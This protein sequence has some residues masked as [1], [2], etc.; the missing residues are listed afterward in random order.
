[1]RRKLIVL[2]ALAVLMA[3]GAGCSV[4]KGMV[5]GEPVAEPTEE[6]AT[7]PGRPDAPASPDSD[8]RADPASVVAA[9]GRP[10]LIEFFAFW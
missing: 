8:F 3:F 10:Q 9:T 2:A 6:A 5:G 1:M 7:I 4:F